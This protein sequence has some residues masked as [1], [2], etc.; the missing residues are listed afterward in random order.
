M[1]K[2][3]K[4]IIFFLMLIAWMG[5]M[6]AQTSC[7]SGS[8]LVYLYTGY[9][10]DFSVNS[11]TYVTSGVEA[12]GIP[13]GTIATVKHNATPANL[14]VITIDLVDNVP[15]GDTI[16]YVASA[17]DNNPDSWDISSSSN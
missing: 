13:D 6:S 9:G 5:N 14:G 17:K 12:T 1:K 7:S 2:H 3:C 11:T 8:S 10:K 4:P 16:Y 15:F